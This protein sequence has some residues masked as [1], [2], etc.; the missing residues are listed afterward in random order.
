V[1]S[2]AYR[3]GDGER[4]YATL[5]Q[6]NEEILRDRLGLSEQEIARLRDE[7]VIGSVATSKKAKAKLAPE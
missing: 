1:A 5:G 2:V 7:G 4:P 3:Q 6:H